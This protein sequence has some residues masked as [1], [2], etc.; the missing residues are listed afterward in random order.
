MHHNASA[1]CRQKKTNNGNP[2]DFTRSFQVPNALQVLQKIAL[3]FSELCLPT[4]RVT[5]GQ[6]PGKDRAKIK[7][8]DPHIARQDYH[9]D[10]SNG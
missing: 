10:F 9:G 2:T 3:V 6:N 5:V 4:K 7:R 1:F 8:V